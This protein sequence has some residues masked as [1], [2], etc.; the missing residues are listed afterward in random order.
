MSDFQGENDHFQQNVRKKVRTALRTGR[1][2]AR[3]DRG[4]ASLFPRLPSGSV[5]DGTG[6]RSKNQTIFAKMRLTI[7]IF[8][9]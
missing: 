3:S 4:P 8:R 6:A 2:Y 5:R 1:R 9:V 7:V